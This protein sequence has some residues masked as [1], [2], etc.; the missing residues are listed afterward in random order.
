MDYKEAYRGKTIL[1]TGGAGAIG[2]NL[3]QALGELGAK[4]VIVLG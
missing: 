4:T 2:S 3:T 1:V